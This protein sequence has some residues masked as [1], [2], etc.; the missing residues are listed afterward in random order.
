MV[1]AG[2]GGCRSVPGQLGG[3]VTLHLLLFGQQSIPGLGSLN[4]TIFFILMISKSCHFIK[5][6]Q[7]QDV[8]SIIGVGII[9]N[10]PSIVRDS[11][12][13]NSASQW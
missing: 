6:L 1:I 13:P 11:E 10:V 9:P 12:D 8:F 7:P 5:Q 2:L 3:V 4:T